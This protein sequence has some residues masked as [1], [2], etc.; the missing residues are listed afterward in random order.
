M[1]LALVSFCTSTAERVE[2]RV[3]VFGSELKQ[4]YLI[5]TGDR[6]FII[7]GHDEAKWRE[8][9]DILEDKLDQKVI[10]LQEEPSEG[11]TVIGKFEKLADDC[12]YAFALLTPDD[13]VEKEGKSYFQARPNVLLELGWFYGRFGRDRVCI[14]KKLKTEIP[15]DLAGILTINFHSDISEA[16]AKIEAELRRVGVIAD[17]R[18]LARRSGGRGKK[19]ITSEV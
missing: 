11:E 18:G 17:A 3:E 12:C 7:H 13:F 8:L 10:V 14:V 6:V 2:T 15:S 16:F 9:R 5:P 1:F 4:R 19:R